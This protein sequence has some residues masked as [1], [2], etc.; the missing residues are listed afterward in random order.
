[1]IQLTHLHVQP[2]GVL[3]DYL[4]YMAGS[5]EPETEVYYYHGDH[6]GSA[7]WITDSGGH[8]IQHL[9]Y[10]PFGQPYVD[11]RI[12]GYHERFT[13]TGT[14]KDEE[15]GY[16]YFGARYMDHELMT[17]WLS[18]DPMSDKY[19]SIS[20]YA[21]CAWNPVK[22]VDPDGNDWYQ[23]THENG[24]TTIEHCKDKA[25]CPSDG[26]Y[27]GLTY[28]DKKNSTYYPLYGQKGISYDANNRH[29]VDAV[30]QMEQTDN[31]I[32]RIVNG[33]KCAHNGSRNFWDKHNDMI[34]MCS[35]IVSA[36]ADQTKYAPLKKMLK[37]IGLYATANSVLD[38]V[39][40][41]KN[42][43]WNTSTTISLAADVSSLVGGFYGNVISFY[44]NGIN[45]ASKK[46]AEAESTLRH[47]FSPLTPNNYYRNC[48]GY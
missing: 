44:L 16:G 18:V 21:Y 19:P 25:S 27:L 15:T 7:S 35:D 12:S 9:E 28:H 11:R 31:S 33:I 48:F 14:E 39:K 13:F 37:P 30:N 46:G 10:L 43:S 17:M 22:L 29:Q 5:S 38:Y 8:A 45:F 26:K 1:M 47:Y 32:I 36:G 20:P 41:I 3:S 40:S 42:G 34:N 6:L 23:K 24:K 2:S 4:P